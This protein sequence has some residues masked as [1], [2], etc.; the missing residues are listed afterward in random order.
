[1]Q[2]HLDK[3]G[4]GFPVITITGPRQSGK[5]TLAK[6]RYLDHV[7]YDLEDYDTRQALQNNPRSLIKDA[8]ARYIIDEFQLVPDILSLIKVMVDRSQIGQQFILT[9]SNQY[10]MMS[11]LSQSLAGRTAIF[12]LL[13]L[14]YEEIHGK[15]RIE[16]E[17]F[18]FKGFYPRL[19]SGDMD[20]QVFYSSYIKT[21]LERDI[22]L[23]SKVHDLDLFRRFLGLCAG[24]TGS[25]LN[26][27]ALANETGIDVKTANSW[28]SLLQAGFI[29][30]LLMPWHANLNKRLVKTPK[31]YFYDTGLACRLLKIRNPSELEFHPSKGQ[32]FE[33]FVVS[34]YLK[35]FNNQGYEAPLYFYRE[36]G[37]TE[38]DLLIQTGAI[39]TP[40]EIKSAQNYHPSFLDQIRAFRRTGIKTGKARLIYAGELEWEQDDTLIK[41]FYT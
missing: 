38:I 10:G 39:L 40:V 36:N 22:S 35:H 32:I 15:V 4:R 37:G 25:L 26:K 31:L 12:Q 33:T 6:L 3:A 5:T 30:Y 7:Y 14:S 21:Y 24:R 19:I 17:E 1:M 2:S 20:P 28:L 23:L 29:I 34:E 18:L 27:A 9:G 11:G 13:P 41:P 8:K 16:P